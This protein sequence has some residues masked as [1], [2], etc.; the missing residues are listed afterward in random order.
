MRTICL[1]VLPRSNSHAKYSFVYK[2]QKVFFCLL[3]KSEKNRK[4]A[5]S[6]K[7]TKNYPKSM[8]NHTETPRNILKMHKNT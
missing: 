7:I 1:A 6:L 5:K 2:A 8:Q 4:M 3:Q